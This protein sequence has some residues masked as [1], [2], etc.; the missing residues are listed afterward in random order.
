MLG[1]MGAFTLVSEIHPQI[2]FIFNCCRILYKNYWSRLG[3]DHCYMLK[4]IILKRNNLHILHFQLTNRGVQ[5]YA[6]VCSVF[7]D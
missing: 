7:K 6:D 2:S 1:M 3:R 5:K 4:I